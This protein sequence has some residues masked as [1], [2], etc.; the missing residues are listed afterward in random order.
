M[1]LGAEKLRGLQ[2]L[3]PEQHELALLSAHV[4]E[5]DRFGA[6]EKFFYE[7]SRVPGFALRVEAML[8]REEFP[9]RLEELQ[10]QL[11]GLVHMCDELIHNSSLRV[12]L[13]L[14]LQLGNCVNAGSYAGNAAGFK[15]N[16]LPKLLDTRANKPRMT[17]LHYVVQVAETNNK[18]ALAFI[19]D[20]SNI[21][22]I[23]KISVEGLEVEIRQV[24]ADIKKLDS[25][26]NEDRNGIRSYFKE[27]MERA[28]LAVGEL[29]QGVQNVKDASARLARHFC[30]DPD[31]FQLEECLK[32]FADFF[33]RT[34]EVH[35][36]NEQR[37]KQEQRGAQRTVTNNLKNKKSV[38]KSADSEACLVDRLMAE[39]RSGTFKLR[40]SEG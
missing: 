16:T 30:E 25:Q 13:T 4:N 11:E 8:Q 14:I 22:T 34:D 31:K 24:A 38:L 17:F 36:E 20:L 26:L 23:C 5:A 32:L 10:P 15:L 6:A 39:I 9:T 33:R 1:E 28:L 21:S 3:L 2:R 27:F 37:Q 19:K 35:K 40:R 29:E 18:D 12:F 7:L